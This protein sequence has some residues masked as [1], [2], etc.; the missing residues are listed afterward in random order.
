VT[1]VS[2]A[3]VLVVG[4]GPAGCA[5]ALTLA[6]RGVEVRLIDAA[7]FPR[8]KVCGDVLL[9]EAQDALQ[10]LGVST[11]ALMSRSHLLTGCR[12][13]TPSGR[14]ASLPFRDLERGD[15]PWWVLPR[16]DLDQFLLQ[17]VRDAGVVVEEGRR[18]TDLLLRDGAVAGV[19]LRE[20]DGSSASVTARAVIAADGASSAL[21]RAAGLFG[22]PPSHL[23]VALRG[24]AE[25]DGAGDDDQLSIFTTARTLP[26][27][28]WVVPCG[29]GRA[30]IGIGVLR[31]D[32]R[33]R[34]VSLRQLADEVAAQHEV[35][36]RAW[37]T[38]PALAGWSLPGASWPRRH[39]RPG[40]LLIGDAGGMVDPFTGHGI[41]AALIAGRLAGE[42]LRQALD[43]GDVGLDALAPFEAGWRRH[44]G[45][46][47]RI[48]WALQRL[49]ASPW[50]V[51]TLLRYV[52]HG[53]RW[54]DLAGG[55]VGHAFPRRALLSPARLLGLARDATR[56]RGIG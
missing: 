13:A 31:S 19:T 42:V 12:Y 38:E 18:A 50:R 37:R 35:F 20:A 8:D 54:R 51:E 53:Q 45:A 2:A 23:S 15:R 28:A 48:G 40:L 47:V 10:A 11:A 9:P 41:H 46:E 24:Y 6:R 21:A 30:N 32:L 56:G 34:G 22:Q 43:R 55:L 52:D 1:C 17:Q 44:F 49:C 7:R 36:G 16:L 33:R 29:K 14:E 5:A 3:P 39:S 26:G 4:A 25:L 27:C